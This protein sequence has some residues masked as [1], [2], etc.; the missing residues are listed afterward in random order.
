MD[1]FF[2]A[3]EQ[4]DHPELRGIPIAVGHD[5][6]RGVVSTASYEARKYGVRSALSI[7]VAKRL[8]PHLVIV[9]SHYHHYKEVSMQVHE[10]FMEF[11]DLIEPLSIDEAFLDVTATCEDF[12]SAVEVGKA[13]QTRIHEELQLTASV[14]IS[15]NKFLAKI[16]SDYHKPKGMFVITP[17]D[18]PM[19]I[20][21]LPVGKIWGVG[22]RTQMRMHKMGI[23]TGAELRKVSLKHLQEVFGKVGQLYYDFA[24]GFDPREVEP[25]SVRKSVGCERTFEEDVTLKS[26]MIIELYHTVVELVD[27][28]HRT[29]FRGKTLT[30]KVKYSNF[31]QVTRSIT[32]S[33]EL[34]SK[35]DI[36]PLA[37]Q[38]LFKVDF[39]AIHTV[40]LMGLSVSNPLVNQSPKRSQQWIQGKLDFGDGWDVGGPELSQ[41]KNP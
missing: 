29:R 41:F 1:A 3:I 27:R 40:R 33:K 19:F 7:V 24:R 17:D 34:H 25:S 2:A 9:D 32:S 28:L 23:F 30:L 14:G 37:K 15:Y 11:T 8:C 20:S 31:Q 18:A 22:P 21:S 10:I 13:I 26:Q 6:S 36:L 39:S 35:D 16:A 12:Q 5:S 38:L 4:R